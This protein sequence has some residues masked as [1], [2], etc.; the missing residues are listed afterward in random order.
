MC[1]VT[2]STKSPFA[3]QQKAKNYKFTKQQAKCH[4]SI[5]MGKDL[6]T[7]YLYK[8]L[9]YFC[10][11]DI[12]QT[13]LKLLFHPYYIHLGNNLLLHEIRAALHFFSFDRSSIYE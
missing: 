12:F 3:R 11:N 8:R 2:L 7:Y 5:Y 13:A 4:L 9:Q 10:F 6:G 1:M